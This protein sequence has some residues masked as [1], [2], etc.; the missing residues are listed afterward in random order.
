MK[1]K[2]LYLKAKRFDESDEYQT[3]EYA[4]IAKRQIELYT[5]MHTLFGPAILP[6]LEEYTAQIGEEYELEC[7]HFFA[8]GYLMGKE[9]DMEGK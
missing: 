1:M 6:L 3:P 5:E 4:R 7:Q 2:D 8:Q 9:E